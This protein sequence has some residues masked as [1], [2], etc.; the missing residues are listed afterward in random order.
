MSTPSFNDIE[1]LSAYLDGELSQDQKT[2]LVAR[3]VKEPGL[4]KALEELRQVR[5]LLQQTPRRRARRNFTLTPKMA[6]IRPPVPRVVPALSWASAVAM[7]L[8]LCTV[9]FNFLAQGGL[10]AAAPKASDRYSG[11]GPATMA[12][13]MAAPATAA[14]ATAA[15]AEAETATPA[16]AFLAP[17]PTTPP[18][19][20]TAAPSGGG[21]GSLPTKTG[22]SGTPS[23]GVTRVFSTPPAP[24]STQQGVVEA[25]TQGLSNITTAST[26]QEKRAFPWQYAWLAL[27][28]IL[29]GAALLI[30]WLNLRSFARQHGTK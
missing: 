7:I 22:L 6:G 26:P 9:S 30:R 15:P 25:P 2:R 1:K 10:G 28:A 16:P 5:A 23:A 3:I 20:S 21:K 8:F 12:P 11:S 24:L 29:I 4:A 18:V 14:P 13:A 17:A 19:V 27:A